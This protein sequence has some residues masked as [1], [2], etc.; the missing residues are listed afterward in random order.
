MQSRLTDQLK[1]M[2]RALRV[3]D[4]VTLHRL[5]AAWSLVGAGGIQ[6]VKKPD[7]CASDLV[8]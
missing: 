8:A 2:E 5:R 4:S 6:F 3:K 1:V 7:A